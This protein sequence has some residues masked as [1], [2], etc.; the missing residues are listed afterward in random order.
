M[1]MKL[2]AAVTVFLSLSSIAIG[3]VDATPTRDENDPLPGGATCSDADDINAAITES[4]TND[5]D[6]VRDLLDWLIENGAYV[7]DKVQ[8][9]HM[10]IDDPL[11][12][13]GIFATDDMDVGETVCRIPWDL[14]LKPND[15]EEGGVGSEVTTS[16]NDPICTTFDAVADAMSDGGKT[17]Y[18]AYLLAQPKDYTPAFW[19][20]VSGIRFARAR[21]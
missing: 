4:P 11:S 2:V 3:V 21:D 6:L 16:S 8:I 20:Q 7:N 18:G 15:K 12:P 9:R 10:V 1:K 17:P 13:R 19:S 5:D 14:I